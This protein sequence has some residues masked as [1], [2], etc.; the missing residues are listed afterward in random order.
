[1]RATCCSKNAGIYL[2]LQALQFRYEFEAVFVEF[3]LIFFFITIIFPC[4][5]V[6]VAALLRVCVS[7]SLLQYATDVN[8]NPL[9]II[10]ITLYGA[11]LE[12]KSKWNPI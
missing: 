7:S 8:T 6:V 3:E 12:Q 11:C 10:V 9:I 2:M 5:A 4:S 1:M